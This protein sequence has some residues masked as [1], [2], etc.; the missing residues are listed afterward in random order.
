MSET[1]FFSK[2]VGVN[3]S[4]DKISS[5]SLQSKTPLLMANLPF[6]LSRLSVYQDPVRRK[7]ISAKAK[8]RLQD[9]IAAVRALAKLQLA[10]GYSKEKK[11]I[12]VT[13]N[14]LLTAMT[15]PITPPINLADQ[16]DNETLVNLHN[17]A[18][19]PAM[20]TFKFTAINISKRLADLCQKF[21]EKTVDFYAQ[22]SDWLAVLNA[23][24]LY[25]VWGGFLA[26]SVMAFF[27]EGTFGQLPDAQSAYNYAAGNLSYYIY[28]VR[29]FFE[30]L[31]MCR[32]VFIGP[33][34]TQEERDYAENETLS[35]RFITQ[36]DKQKFIL[37]NDFFW[38]IANCVCFLKLTGSTL[39][40]GS[41][42]I[43]FGDTGNFLACAVFLVD[44]VVA[45]WDFI[46]SS[47]RYYAELLRLK[48]D[49]KTLSRM[50]EE[51]ETRLTFAKSI[52]LK[53]D[54]DY[55]NN[56]DNQWQAL[57]QDKIEAQ[58]LL[59]TV[60]LDWKYLRKEKI[61]SI[62]YASMLFLSYTVGCSV[63]LPAAMVTVHTALTCSLAGSLLCF[64]FTIGSAIYKGHLAI[65]K[66]REEADFL[67][68]DAEQMLNAF[69]QLRKKAN[70]SDEDLLELTDQYLQIHELMQNAEAKTRLV[71][72]TQTKLA[73][74]SMV[75]SLFPGLLM[76]AFMSLS[77]GPA[78]GLIIGVMT[79]FFVAWLITT[80]LEKS[81]QSEIHPQPDLFI[82][83]LNADLNLEHFE[84]SQ[85]VV[86]P[87]ILEN[88]GFIQL[89]ESMK[90]NIVFAAT[91]A[92]SPLLGLGMLLLTVCK[93]LVDAT[94]DDRDSEV[95][96][97]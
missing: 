41:T 42:T 82:K 12:L 16:D 95:P 96:A 30:T 68:Q 89:Y 19:G 81:V 17:Q 33:W 78:A 71:P 18:V 40:P 29:Y 28:F 70:M 24:R 5:W 67:R 32:L 61:A 55:A 91:L 72:Y 87:A 26:S 60:E 88:Q 25:W 45:V 34:M 86:Q 48:A 51:L 6:Y 20:A 31:S 64:V 44:I 43:T 56:L 23:D 11:A 77:T 69:N 46:E 79:A 49:L 14:V 4:T 54:L 58:L 22:L 13:C 65:E 52:C 15:T 9:Q 2:K 84:S 62:Y 27:A 73:I 21:P 90:A 8:L 63:L 92:I 85:K 94:V 75:Q 93:M 83:A 10:Q 38:G 76:V 36:L 59:R 97:L 1:N 47:K 57:K 37:I 7:Y 3:S 35:D 53:N 66:A 80:A 74:E 50:E 39:M